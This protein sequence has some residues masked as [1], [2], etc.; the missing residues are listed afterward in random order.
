MVCVAAS[1]DNPFGNAGLYDWVPRMRGA[2]PPDA[3]KVV[4]G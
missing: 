3:A 4:E 1:H 2:V